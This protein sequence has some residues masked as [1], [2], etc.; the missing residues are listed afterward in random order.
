MPGPS[1]PQ[2]P[3][4][5]RPSR[6]EL[7]RLMGEVQRTRDLAAEE[8]ATSA[9]WMQQ[10][11]SRRD[12]LRALEDYVAALEQLAFPVPRQIRDELRLCRTLCGTTTPRS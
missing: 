10:L 5:N 2:R 7:H 9:S 3:T 8:R 1:T 12:S 6:A 4:V 11:E